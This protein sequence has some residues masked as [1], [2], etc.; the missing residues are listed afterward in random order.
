MKEIEKWIMERRP[1]FC[2]KCG[3]KLYYQSGGTYECEC[4]VL[5]S[6]M[7]LES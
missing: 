1:I 3:G 6:W 4:A 7:T 5:R 2:K